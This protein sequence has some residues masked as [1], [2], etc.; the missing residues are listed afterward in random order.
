[1][2]P[3]RKAS[4]NLCAQGAQSSAALSRKKLQKSTQVGGSDQ[5]KRWIGQHQNI[6]GSI[7]WEAVIVGLFPVFSLHHLYVR[8]KHDVSFSRQPAL[9]TKLLN[10]KEMIYKL[11]YQIF[12][13]PEL[14]PIAAKVKFPILKN[15]TKQQQ[16]RTNL[17]EP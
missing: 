10:Y 13:S 8:V 4:R 15:K 2:L 5:M 9:R 6:S 1:M 17:K 14:Q 7:W 12:I 11:K 16:P 3:G